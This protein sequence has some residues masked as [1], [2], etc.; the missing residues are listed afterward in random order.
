MTSFDLL[1]ALGHTSVTAPKPMAEFAAL[2]SPSRVGAAEH[3]EAQTA[4][5]NSTIGTL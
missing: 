5:R 3:T 4:S 1:P 2:F